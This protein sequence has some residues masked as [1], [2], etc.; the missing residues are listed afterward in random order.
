MSSRNAFS[1]FS[2]QYLCVISILYI[3]RDFR[4]IPEPVYSRREKNGTL[5]KNRPQRFHGLHKCLSWK[6]KSYFLRGR[7]NEGFMP[8]RT[9]WFILYLRQRKFQVLQNVIFFFQAPEI[10]FL[11]IVVHAKIRYTNKTH[12]TTICVQ[13][14]K[15][16]R[17]MRIPRKSRILIDF[18]H[19]EKKLDICK[20]I[21]LN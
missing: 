1:L 19:F 10:N 18:V 5:A 15:S 2:A 7:S 13:P 4:I 9:S 12:T 11:R 8:I 20:N 17:S 6:K 3:A 21:C 14:S 16:I